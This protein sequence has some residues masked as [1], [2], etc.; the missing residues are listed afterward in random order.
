MPA[1]AFQRLRIVPRPRRITLPSVQNI[2]SLWVDASLED[3]STN[4]R[5][6]SHELESGFCLPQLRFHGVMLTGVLVSSPKA[7]KTIMW[8]GEPDHRRRCF[9]SVIGFVFLWEIGVTVQCN[10][11]IPAGTCLGCQNHV[12]PCGGSKVP[13]NRQHAHLT[14]LSL[15]QLRLK[16]RSSPRRHSCSN[17]LSTYSSSSVLR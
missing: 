9:N 7:Q 12:P 13:P 1:F 15:S 2:R 8:D 14:W 16:S 17:R 11:S 4:R 10:G 3:R 5:H 6:G